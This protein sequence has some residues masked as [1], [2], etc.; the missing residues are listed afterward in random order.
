MP[1]PQ[2]IDQIQGIQPS[3]ISDGPGDD[4]QSLG[5]H[6]HHELLLA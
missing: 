6:V 5:E 4:F 3:V 1:V 2:F